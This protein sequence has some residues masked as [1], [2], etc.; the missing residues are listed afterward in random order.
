MPE[1][2]DIQLAAALIIQRL[3]NGDSGSNQEATRF[4]EGVESG[5]LP[6][7]R[8]FFLNVA[9]GPKELPG[10]AAYVYPLASETEEGQIPVG[11]VLLNLDAT[12]WCCVDNPEI[13]W[14]EMMA[15]CI[16]HEMIHRQ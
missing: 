13:H 6:E 14:Q 11:Q 9:K 2:S 8:R 4:L 7:P 16:S 3:L 15:E 12:L 5:E 10:F 1:K